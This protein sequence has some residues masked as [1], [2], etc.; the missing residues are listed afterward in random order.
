MTL[1]YRLRWIGNRSCARALEPLGTTSGT[2]GRAAAGPTP[3]SRSFA[4]TI[5]AT[6]A[7]R[8]PTSP[9]RSRRWPTAVVELLD[10]SDLERVSFCGLSLG[11]M[12]GMALALRAPE[13]V[14]RLVLCCTAAYLGPAER[15]AGA[16]ADRT[17]R[18]DWRR[19]PSACSSA[20][21]PSA[22][23]RRTHP[24]WPFPGDARA[25]S[26][27]GLRGVLRGD[28]ATG[29]PSRREPSTRPRW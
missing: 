28:R 17:R 26:R 24:R 19:L 3:T 8:S 13:R 22:S 10:A 6:A 20:G 16:R 27:G 23:A 9:S 2:S 18:G 15:L 21:S 5:P 14:D 7:R 1:S 29:M 11:G 4:T 25:H 12:V